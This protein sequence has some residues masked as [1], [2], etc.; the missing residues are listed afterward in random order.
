MI[1]EKHF[2]EMAELRAQATSLLL[3]HLVGGR[4]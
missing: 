4:A 3:A 2:S 1:N